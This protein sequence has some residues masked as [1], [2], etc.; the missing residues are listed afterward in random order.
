MGK[1]DH[2]WAFLDMGSISMGLDKDGLTTT[3]ATAPTVSDCDGT[4]KI[5]SK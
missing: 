1:K 3:D 2:G 4:Y 5:L